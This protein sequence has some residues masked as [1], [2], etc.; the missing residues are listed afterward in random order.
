VALIKALGGSV[1]DCDLEQ[2]RGC[3]GGAQ[4]L[5]GFFQQNVSDAAA[6]VRG[7]DVD[8][9]ETTEDIPVAALL[10]GNGESGKTAGFILRQHADVP[11]VFQEIL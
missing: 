2:D 4:Q 11:G 5:L 1:I 9:D 6:A 3:P 10:S 7:I 8:G